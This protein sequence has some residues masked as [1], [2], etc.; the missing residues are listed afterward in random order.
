[1]PLD[2]HDVVIDTLLHHLDPIA[3]GGI[4]A[5][6]I[7][8]SIADGKGTQ[9]VEYTA[10]ISSPCL[11]PLIG[12][13]VTRDRSQCYFT[14]CYQL[15]EVVIDISSAAHKVKVSCRDGED[16]DTPLLFACH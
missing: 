6:R 11:R 10:M 16:F 5:Y 14:V 12:R 3:P 9:R 4:G 8:S 7:E 1:M 13:Q 2:S 15:Q